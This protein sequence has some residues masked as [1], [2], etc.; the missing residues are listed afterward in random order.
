MQLIRRMEDPVVAKPVRMPPV[1]PDL[2]QSAVLVEKVV[3][4]N[5]SAEISVASDAD[6]EL[7]DAAPSKAGDT[8]VSKYIDDKDTAFTR[9]ED[10][11]WISPD[12]VPFNPPLRSRN[13]WCPERQLDYAKINNFM[14]ND[15]WHHMLMRGLVIFFRHWGLVDSNLDA[16][17]QQW[18][19]ITQKVK[20]MERG[21]IVDGNE[22]FD[23]AYR[24]LYHCIHDHARVF[25]TKVDDIWEQVE[26]IVFEDDEIGDTANS[27]PRTAHEKNWQYLR[28]FSILIGFYCR[29]TEK[30]ENRI[31]QLMQYTNERRPINFPETIK[32]VN[33]GLKIVVQYEFEILHKAGYSVPPGWIRILEICAWGMHSGNVR[34]EYAHYYHTPI[35]HLTE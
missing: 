13:H 27:N 18:I 19:Y 26:R 23:L 29:L 11:I 22:I 9:R 2:A 17:V 1:P 3:Q 25:G 20:D 16:N 4:N 7:L 31:S 33:E 28:G 15:R 8:V 6:I 10:G 24:N 30:L 12:G 35:Y 21:R 5:T 34:P 14:A 32:V